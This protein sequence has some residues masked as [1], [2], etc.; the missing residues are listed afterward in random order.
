MT[1][2][3]EKFLL[4]KAHH[5]NMVPWIYTVNG[6]YFHSFSELFIWLCGKHEAVT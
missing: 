5:N 3:P 4:E 1:Q 6:V 2:L